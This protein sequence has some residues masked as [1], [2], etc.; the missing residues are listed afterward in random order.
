[1]RAARPGRLARWW[2][3]AVL[4][5]LLGLALAVRLVWLDNLPY[6]FHGDEGAFG[7]EAQRIPREGG[8]GP[9]SPTTLGQPAGLMYPAALSVWLLGPTVFAVRAVPAL[10]AIWNEP[11][12]NAEQRLLSNLR[13]LAIMSEPNVP[14]S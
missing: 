10:A 9:W 6:G 8:I 13:Q 11:E 1:M 5:G 12:P 7:L 14:G 3:P 4:L 2:E